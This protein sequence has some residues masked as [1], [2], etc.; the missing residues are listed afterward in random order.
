MK[1]IHNNQLKIGLTAMFF[2]WFLFF[3][4]LEEGKFNRLFYRFI[5]ELMRMLYGNTKQVE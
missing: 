2:P 3:D 1:D 5:A 4:L